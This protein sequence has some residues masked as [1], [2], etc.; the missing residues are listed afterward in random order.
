MIAELEGK[1]DDNVVMAGAHLDSVIEGPGINDNGS[2]SA[3]LLE[4]ALMMAKVEAAR[5]PSGSRGGPARSR[6]WSGRRTTSRG[7]RRPSATASRCTSTTTWSA[8]RTTSSW[9]TTRTSRRSR[10]R[11]RSQPGSTAIED[12]YESYYTSIGEPYDDSAFDGRSD[13]Q[14]FIDAGIPS[15]GLFTGAE[16]PKTEEQQAIWGGIGR[17]A[18]RPLLP[19]GVRHL[20]QRRSAR[21]RGQQRPDR[22]RAADVRVLDRVGQRRPGQERPGHEA[23]AARSGRPR[24]HVPRGRRRPRARRPS[25]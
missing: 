13:Y 10:R 25:S 22:L 3:A 24:G 1:N 19:R 12:L 21:A 20:R 6:A 2:G 18:V 16:V 7:C 5:T 17:G 11:W 23:Q 9:C 15:G 8:R 4:T 14:A